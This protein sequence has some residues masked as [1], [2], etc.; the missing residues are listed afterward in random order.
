MKSR[1]VTLFAAAIVLALG[2]CASLTPTEPFAVI[3]GTDWDRTDPYAAPVQ[4]ASIDGKDYL[5]LSHRALPPGPHKI[6]F[7]TT[8][9]LRANR[10]RERHEVEIDLKPC[11]AYYFYAKHPSKF[12][13]HWELK[14]LRE[15]HLE[16]CAQ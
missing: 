3:D 6:G 5:R 12:D 10:L 2:A 16:S 1:I 11:T 14:T 15:V 9:V 8:Q 4:I 13:P 7:L